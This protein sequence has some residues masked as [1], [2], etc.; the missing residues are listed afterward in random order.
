[1]TGRRALRSRSCCTRSLREIGLVEA[2]CSEETLL[3]LAKVEWKR[4]E[5]RK[6][7][8]S[9]VIAMV[10]EATTIV[11]EKIDR[12]GE[13]RTHEVWKEA[14]NCKKALHNSNSKAYD[15]ASL[16]LHVSP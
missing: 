7:R 2:A 6:R 11:L 8:E 10:L 14:T 12:R 4:E 3:F 1:M 15:V 13:Q 5:R 16:T 9:K